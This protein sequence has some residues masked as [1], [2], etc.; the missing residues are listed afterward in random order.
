[1]DARKI[2]SSHAQGL[3]LICDFSQMIMNM[4]LDSQLN[5]LMLSLNV[6]S[7]SDLESIVNRTILLVI[8]TAQTV[9]TNIAYLCRSELFSDV[10]MSGL[11][12]NAVAY[13][14]SNQTNLVSI[15][16]AAY[17]M[18]DDS[19]CHCLPFISCSLPAAIYWNNQRPNSII[20]DTKGNR[21]LIKG[22]QSNCYP[23]YGLLAS[24]LEC[25]Y[26]PS[27]LQLLIPY[28]MTFQPLN[29]TTPSRFKP[30]VLVED[31]LKEVMLEELVFNYSVGSYYK[32]CAPLTCTYSYTNR[33]SP[34]NVVTIIIGLMA[35]IRTILRFIIP[36]VIMIILKCKRR[37]FSSRIEQN[38]ET[39]RSK[40]SVNLQLY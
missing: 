31:L 12:T 29:S 15:A 18:E 20:H 14:H 35:G 32:A 4:T 7:S 39:I 2:A 11:G 16:S 25:Y 23:F 30:E 36:Y 9:I 19:V 24:T 1:M 38:P 3:Q 13:I 6:I 26:E 22:M 8:Q 10:F 5:T 27:C 21:T 37:K 33:N 40:N 34:L 28:Y 17:R